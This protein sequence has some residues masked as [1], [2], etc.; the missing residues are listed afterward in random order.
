MQGLKCREQIPTSEFDKSCGCKE[1]TKWQLVYTP[2]ENY[3]VPGFRLRRLSNG[4]KYWKKII[5]FH[6]MANDSGIYEL[7]VQTKPCKRLQTVYS[8]V[9][10]SKSTKMRSKDWENVLFQSLW[11]KSDVM[12]CIRN[13]TANKG[14]RV[15]LRQLKYSSKLES[16]VDR[17][18]YAWKHTKKR[19]VV[20]NGIQIS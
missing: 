13:V 7:A 9:Y 8:R 10:H 1:K 15:F 12:K 14:C 19:R 6:K 17:T 18:D 3:K 20:R 5:A 16:A 2:D 4:N 11:K